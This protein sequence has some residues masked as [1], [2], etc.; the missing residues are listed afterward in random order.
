MKTIEQYAIGLVA[1]GAES[2]AEDDL[3]EDGEIN[4]SDH[5][6][7]CRLATQIAYGIRKHPAVA[8][9]AAHL[10]EPA[11]PPGS[12]RAVAVLLARA[13]GNIGRLQPAAARAPVRDMLAAGIE[14]CA[15]STT[16]LGQPIE[17]LVT[18]ATALAEEAPE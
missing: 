10:G 1:D 13:L 6:A 15:I 2:T 16:L 3:N 4:D 8:L 5:Q 18:L 17:H 14:R 11:G 9:A 12:P 7:A